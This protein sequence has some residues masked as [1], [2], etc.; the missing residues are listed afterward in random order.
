MIF[1]SDIEPIA[2]DYLS[3]ML[4]P[5]PAALRYLLTP[6]L[7]NKYLEMTQNKI[8]AMDMYFA[9]K[10]VAL[11]RDIIKRFIEDT[12]EGYAD[13]ILKRLDEYKDVIDRSNPD[14]TRVLVDDK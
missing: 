4:V 14:Q 13:T 12:I 3:R 9:S 5:Y 10:G 6:A 8:I 7:F 11:N 2:K 1:R